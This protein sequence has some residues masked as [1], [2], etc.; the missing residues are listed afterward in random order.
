MALELRTK[1]QITDYVEAQYAEIKSQYPE[2]ELTCWEDQVYD[3]PPSNPA[4]SIGRPDSSAFYT[5]EARPDQREFVIFYGHY[6]A[7]ANPPVGAVPLYQRAV[8][9]YFPDAWPPGFRK[10]LWDTASLRSALLMMLANQET[11]P[12]NWISLT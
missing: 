10:E 4:W 6:S 5:L 7:G 11:Y 1:T 2:F 3:G 9:V 12:M 8:H